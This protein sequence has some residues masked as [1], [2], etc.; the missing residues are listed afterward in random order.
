[1]KWTQDMSVG[2]ETI[3]A[4]HR[5]LFKRINDLL[6]AIKEHRCKTE[7]DGTIKFLDDYARFH[8]SEEEKDMK[9]AG[10]GGLEN[11]RKHHAVYLSNIKDLKEL[12]SQPRIQGM[13]YELSVTTNQV[14][15]D[16][17]VDHIMKIDKQF[18][19]FVK[20]DSRQ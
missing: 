13:S 2:I 17:I 20:K 14:V 16:W 5:E 18:G 19:E 1:M 11:H 4:Q 12:A 9:E 6:Q 7:I 3:D 15:V 10:Y 8:F